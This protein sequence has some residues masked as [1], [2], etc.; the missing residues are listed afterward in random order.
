M[1]MPPDGWLGRR[2]NRE[3][4][5]AT[6][7]VTDRAK[8]AL[9][10][11]GGWE[12]HQPHE[13]AG[14]LRG[15]LA[16]TMASRSPSA[17]RSTSTSMRDLLRQTRPDRADLDAERRSRRSRSSGLLDAVASG[18]GIAGW[19]GGMADSFRNNTEYQFMVG[20]QWVA[21]PGNIIDYTVNITNHDDP[22][23]AGLNDFSDALRAVLPARRPVERG[24]GD[25]HLQRRAR[26]LDRRHA[27]C[28][29]SGSGD[30]ARAGSST[31]RSATSPAISTCPRRARSSGAACTG[32]PLVSRGGE[33]ARRR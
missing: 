30:G 31:A 18:V 9:L 7:T 23:T 25:D 4:R 21:H 10:V 16:R 20:G 17:R 33:E 22:I 27:S 1:M 19:H 3:I 26:P 15:C 24:A 14:A 32:P 13:C 5:E 8:R 28:R 11:A 29:S 12:G 6:S 2:D